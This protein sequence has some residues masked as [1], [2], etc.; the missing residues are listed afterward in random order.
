MLS[1]TQLY[2]VLLIHIDRNIKHSVCYKYF[3]IYI[4]SYY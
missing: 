3:N 1:D 4:L 2:Y